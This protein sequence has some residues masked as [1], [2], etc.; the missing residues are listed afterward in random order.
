M[1]VGQPSRTAFAAARARALHQL[2]DPPRVFTDPLAIPILGADA[3]ELIQPDDV[4]SRRTQ[5]FIALRS[6]FADDAIA[7][8]V[9]TG[10][11]QVVV[12]G[13]GLDTFGCRNPHAGVRVFEVDHPD[14]QVWK[15]ARLAD[16]GI[17][18]PPSLVFAPVDFEHQGLG[19]GLLAAGFDRTSPAIFVWLGVVQYLTGEA[20]LATLQF[21]AS[22]NACAPVVFDYREPPST[23]TGQGLAEFDARARRVADLGEPW[24]TFFTPNDIADTL[25]TIGFKTVA[26]HTGAD[27]YTTYTGRSPRADT[28][29]TTHVVLGVNA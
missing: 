18:I 17:D 28:R 2:A 16:A 19:D 8:A 27:L 9:A 21:I 14:T 13:A 15:R 12:L 4:Q 25:N 3:A 7:D 6:R 10:T 26:D 23:L 11:R 22:Q 29:S 24:L 1:E 20:V 5:L